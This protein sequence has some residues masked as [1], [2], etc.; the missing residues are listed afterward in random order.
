M[1]QIKAQLKGETQV[2]TGMVRFSFLN[3]FNPR[4]NDD[5]TPGKYDACL[6]IDKGDKQTLAC[7][8]KA[9]K[10]ATERGIREK[11]GG[12]MPK[13]FQSPL[14]DGDERE[15]DQYEGF[16][17]SMFLNAKSKSRPGLIN[18]DGS[19]IIDEEDLYSGCY[20]CASITFY[21]YSANSNNGVGVALNN[22]IKLKD[23]DSLGGKPSAENDF[24]DI[25]GSIE[26]EDDED[27]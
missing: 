24:G 3:V 22:L 14:K 5:G 17:G 9:I 1:A 18:R 26:D 16:E 25:L 27:L 10:S 11:W 2:I 12:K 21:P 19:K 13:K 6:I 20:G 23:G 4:I 7:I 8:D 15:D